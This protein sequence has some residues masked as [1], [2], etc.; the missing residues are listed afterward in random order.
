[1]KI[2]SRHLWHIL[3][4]SL[5]IATS[6]A[7][8]G[9]NPNIQTNHGG[10]LNSELTNEWHLVR[11]PNP[12]GGADAISIMH[13]PDTARSDIDLA[14]LMI[15]CRERGTEVAIAL[16]RAYSVRTKPIVIFGEP[17]NETRLETTIAAPGTVVLLP[18]NANALVDGLWRAEKDLFLQIDDG[19]TPIHGVI[20]LAGLQAAFKLLTANCQTQ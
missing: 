6:N 17:G 15:R 1:M 11:T 9:A 8:D 12:K 2:T 3:L 10:T 4:T 19:Q 16:L 7:A 5:A 20:P 13:T 14:G 18:G